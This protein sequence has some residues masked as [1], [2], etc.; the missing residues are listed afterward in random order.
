[1]LSQLSQGCLCRRAHF[2]HAQLGDQMP[3]IGMQTCER[4]RVQALQGVGQ[5]AREGAMCIG[6]QGLTF[7]RGVQVHDPAVFVVAAIMTPPDPFSQL[8]LAVP[9]LGLFFLG[10]WLV[11]WTARKQG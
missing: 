1:M 9:L 4:V 10:Y 11:R 2:F 7:G 5:Q 6:Q 3:Q 8:L